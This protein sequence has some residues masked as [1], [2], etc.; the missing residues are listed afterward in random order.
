MVV[1]DVNVVVD[2][3]LKKLSFVNDELNRTNLENIFI[4]TASDKQDNMP[5]INYELINHSQFTKQE[6]S[7]AKNIVNSQNKERFERLKSLKNIPNDVFV[8]K[9]DPGKILKAAK[10]KP[11]SERL[12]K[13]L[14]SGV[15]TMPVG[16]K[17]S[18]KQH[19]RSNIYKDSPTKL[20]QSSNCGSCKRK[21]YGKY[22]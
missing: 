20:E 6:Q 9:I 16:C 10:Q 7:L 1:Y 2:Q 13:S 3:H 11:P 5:K 4:G 22:R 18:F 12:D 17:R 21:E 15:A 19:L 14:T 8:T